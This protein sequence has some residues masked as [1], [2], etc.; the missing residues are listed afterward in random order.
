[1]SVNA[2]EAD[3]GRLPVPLQ[4]L[5]PLLRQLHPLI[6]PTDNF[7]TRLSSPFC[8]NILPRRR[9]DS[10]LY[11]PPSCSTQRGRFANVTDVG[12]GCGGRTLQGRVKAT[13]FSPRN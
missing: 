5:F 9:P 1:M 6:C 7:S 4:K 2:I 8:K 12:T 13:R 11:P 10:N 3:L